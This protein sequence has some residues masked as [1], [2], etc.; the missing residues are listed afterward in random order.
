MLFAKERREE[1]KKLNPEAKFGEIGKLL[2]EA[3]KG[4]EDKTKYEEMAKED[5]KR[6]DNETKIEV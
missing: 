4:L 6:Y 3:W 2:G 5:K 1:I